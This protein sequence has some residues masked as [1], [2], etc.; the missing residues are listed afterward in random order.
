MA[1]VKNPLGSEQARGA[2]GQTVFMGWRGLQT[3]RARVAPTNPRTA[4]QLDA[5]AKLTALSRSWGT[6]SR[7][8]AALWNAYAKNL[9]L[10]DSL[11]QSYNP[12]GINAYVRVNNLLWLVYGTTTPNST[13]P[14]TAPTAQVASITKQASGGNGELVFEFSFSGTAVALSRVQIM[15]TAGSNSPNRKP[16]ASEYRFHSYALSSVEDV[17]ITGLTPGAYYG[18]A[19]RY[20]DPAGQ[21]T[22]YVTGYFQA[23]AK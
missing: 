3:A 20:I 15:L 13:P 11:G 10:T 19:I 6:L 18:I 8:N 16:A 5:R 9:T 23:E 4:A 12:S 2:K 1:R 14:A 17:T 21:P 22:G 7:A